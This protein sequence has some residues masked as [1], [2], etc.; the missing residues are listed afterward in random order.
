MEERASLH[1][2][3]ISA[4]TIS[5]GLIILR[6]RHGGRVRS[7]RRLHQ[8]LTMSLSL[9]YYSHYT[10]NDVNSI[11]IAYHRICEVVGIQRN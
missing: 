11:Q 8:M 9:N 4:S 1:R 7:S 5:Q 6:R 2:L 3:N 10:T